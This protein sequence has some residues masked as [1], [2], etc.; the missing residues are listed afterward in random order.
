M[1]LLRRNVLLA[2][3]LVVVLILFALAS[4]KLGFAP[5]SSL[6]LSPSRPI[7][8]GT[9]PNDLPLEAQEYFHQAFSPSKPSPYAFPA[10]SHVCKHTQ[11][12]EKEEDIV[13]LKCGAMSAGLTSIMSQLKVC[14]KM[15]LDAGSSL[16]LPSMPLR[17]SNDLQNFNFFNGEAYHDYGEWFEAE[18]LIE[19]LGRACPQM[20]IV[21]PRELDKEVPVKYTWNIDL[22]TAPGFQ[23]FIPYFW[24]GRPFKPFFDDKV[25][26]LRANA[27]KT[28]APEK[29]NGITVITIH[30][31]FLVYRITDDPTGNDLHLWNE[32]GY[33]IRFKKDSRVLVDELLTLIDHPYYGVHFRAEN[34]TIWSSPEHQL[35]VDLDALDRAYSLFSPPS[36]QKPIVY[37]ACGDKAQVASFVSAGAARGWEVT[38][39]WN[40]ASRSPNSQDLLKRLDG[41]EFDFQGSVDMGIMMRGNF[42]LGITGSAFS[43]SI[44]N[45]RDGTGR[46]RGSSF[47]LTGKNGDGG[48]RNHLFN[49]GEAG[50]YPCCL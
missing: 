11:W 4:H 44:A 49:D 9:K 12:P 38:H 33:L 7:P 3:T 5:S 1:S 23:E 39:K 50:G 45:A 20:K 31:M 32:L 25:T 2:S 16:V 47:F 46:Y 6:H 24:P 40:L 17:D 41:L 26:E 18:H 13:Y 27:A 14:F 35:A 19:S 42:F 43:S 36:K 37:L 48:A 29:T 28:P 30:A 22:G 15:A 10:I 34:D 8:H 21:R